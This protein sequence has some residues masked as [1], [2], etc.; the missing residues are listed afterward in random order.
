M[1]KY[2][3]LSTFVLLSS[4]TSVFSMGM[5]VNAPEKNAQD[6]AAVTSNT[7]PYPETMNTDTV[8]QSTNNV[9]TSVRA[10]SPIELGIL[11]DL[12]YNINNDNKGS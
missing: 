10:I 8:N 11:R 2:L 9:G 6:N 1:S 4:C 7:S 12:G 3:I 5:T